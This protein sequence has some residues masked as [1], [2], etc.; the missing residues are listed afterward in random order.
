MHTAPESPTRERLLE[1]AARIFARD[2]L[3][4]ATTREIARAAG[5]NEVTLFRHFRSKD[6]LLQAVVQ[7]NFGSTA[8]P[9]PLPATGN[10]LRADLAAHARAYEQ[11]LQE[12]LPL[13][14][15][16]LGG[17]HRHGEQERQVY[18]A[19]FAPLRAALIARLEAAQEGGRLQPAADAGM[20]ADLFSG[21]IFT[22]VLRRASPIAFSLRS[23]SSLATASSWAFRRSASTRSASATACSV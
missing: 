9:P 11:R 12:N 20:L 15:A 16:M 2:G 19:I 23:A 21:M 10:D 3:D 22:G 8:A 4:G 5:V 6:R 14:R 7:R 1:A 13:I 17:I 18:L